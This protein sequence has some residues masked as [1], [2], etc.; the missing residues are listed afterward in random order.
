MCVCVCVCVF[1]TNR[2]ILC[3]Q[4][5][6]PSLHLFFCCLVCLSGFL[7]LN[8]LFVLRGRHETT[9]K[10]VRKFGYSNALELKD[11]YLHPM[12][13]VQR[14]WHFFLPCDMFTD[15]MAVCKCVCMYVC[16]CVWERERERERVTKA[17]PGWWE[18]VINGFDAQSVQGIREPD[19]LTS[20]KCK[21]I[22]GRYL[23]Y[24][25]ICI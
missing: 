2:P 18:A 22:L 7:F 23:N 21:N 10:V 9:W 17:I 25:H 11:E 13:V 3:I 15:V 12:W 1:R 14:R 5:S 4:H 24:W 16:V 8:K 6:C 19:L 20:T